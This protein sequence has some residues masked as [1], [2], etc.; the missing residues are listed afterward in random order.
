[1]AGSLENTHTFGVSSARRQSVEWQEVPAEERKRPKAGSG[2][3][4]VMLSGGENSTIA[5][6]WALHRFS[7]IAAL[8]FNHAHDHPLQL[9]SA[10]KIAD[11]AKIPL[12]IIPM[13]TLLQGFEPVLT[14]KAG[15]AK[16]NTGHNLATP[17]QEKMFIPGRHLL[18]FA[19]AANRAGIMKHTHLVVGAS[20]ESIAG[21]PECQMAFIR[22]MTKTIS[23]G[24]GR[25]IKIHAPLIHMDKAG[26]ILFGSRFPECMTAMQY[27][28]T[29][30]KDH[31]P[32]CGTCP[33][34]LSRR[35]GFVMAGVEDP[36]CA[37]EHFLPKII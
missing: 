17:C 27:T 28:H 6:F 29:C 33:A 2:R 3:A 5:L 37:T 21:Y 35:R 19:L 31:H 13:G 34:C 9:E 32:P 14:A 20:R 8:T 25:K 22:Q 11:M 16:K 7:R 30:C 1:M 23:A 24:L 12:E 36:L 15:E 4:L 18:Y 26:A 10:C